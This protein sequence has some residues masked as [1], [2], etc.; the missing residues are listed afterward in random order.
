MSLFKRAAVLGLSCAIFACAE[1]TTE[2]PPPAA[3]PVIVM[4]HEA[5]IGP[6]PEPLV[7]YHVGEIRRGDS[8]STALFRLD[9]GAAEVDALAR[10]LDGVLEVRHC[11]PGH[12]FEIYK[13]TQGALQKF[14]YTSGPA[15]VVFAYRTEDSG[16]QAF[17]EPMPIDT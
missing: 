1:S 16:W 3:P 4:D 17:E 12:W 5:P 9:V 11:R 14:R 7:E 15:D 6:E 13:D 10:G 8:L 2:P